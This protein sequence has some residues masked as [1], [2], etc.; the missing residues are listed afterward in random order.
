MSK[1]K[2]TIKDIYTDDNITIK[3]VQMK[4][5]LNGYNVETDCKTIYEIIENTRAGTHFIFHLGGLEH[6]NHESVAYF[7][8]WYNRIKNANGNLTL[9]HAKENILSILDAV[10]LTAEVKH[11]N[12]VEDAKSSILE[13]FK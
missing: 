1:I 4:G 2:I 7:Y 3:M 11:H 8:D 5:E 10:G 12:T 13:L 9:A 6:I